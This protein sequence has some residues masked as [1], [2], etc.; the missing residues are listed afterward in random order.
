VAERHAVLEA[1]IDA[2]PEALDA[3]VLKVVSRARG[4]S[5][6]DAFRAQYRLRELAAS[7][8][9][10]WQQADALLVPTA[11]GH[12]S[13]AALDADPVGENARL[14][15]YTNFVNLLGWCALA[16]PAGRTARACPSG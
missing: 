5:A 3:T 14:G 11:P 1:L 13:F 4:M 8:R 6:T 15:T 9:R 2:Q 7:A 12:P 10:L 16:V